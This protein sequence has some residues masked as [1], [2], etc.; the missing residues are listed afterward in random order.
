MI[1]AGYPDLMMKFLDSNPGL[2]SRFNRFFNFEDYHPQGLLQILQLLAT[3]EGY[4]MHE[5]IPQR[6]LKTTTIIEMNIM[7]MVVMSETIL[8]MCY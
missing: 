7:L 5:T 4:K 3:K 6:I 2:R 1:V 8:K